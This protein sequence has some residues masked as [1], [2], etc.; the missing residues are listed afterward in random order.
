MTRQRIKLG[1]VIA[2]IIAASLIAANAWAQDDSGEPLRLGLIGLDTSHVIAFTSIVN[3]PDHGEHVPG[4]K[5]VA[6]FKGGSP[7]VPSSWN[8]VEKYTEQLQKDFGVEIVDSIPKLCSMVDGVL[9]TSVDG[10][11]HLW[12]AKQ[13]INAGKPMFI[14]KPVAGSFED[15]LEIARLAKAAGVPWFGGSSLR[16]TPQMREAIDPEKVGE[17][18]GCDAFSP[19]SLEPH[20]PDLFW[21][22]VHGVE[23]L[24]AAMGRGCVAVSRSSTP[25]C[26][27]VVG[28]WKNGRIGTFR[29]TRKGA[30]DYGATIFGTK[31]ITKVQGHT[32]RGLVEEIVKFFRTKEAPIDPEETVEMLAFMEAADQSKRLGGAPVR[33][34]KF[35]ED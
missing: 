6:G 30:H 15:G 14:D 16:W 35:P 8:R 32:Y 21:Y 1:V 27:L 25:D 9:I 28:L 5:V 11:P 17:V 10:R 29:G 33:V 4:A 7:D 18:L 34:P 19:C 3:N 24:F 22:G 23:I 2:T 12:Q 13:V 31:A 20:H 26:E